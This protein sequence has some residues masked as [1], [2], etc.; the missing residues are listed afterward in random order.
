L[1]EQQTALAAIKVRGLEKLWLVFFKG[2]F[3]NPL[4]IGALA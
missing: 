1:H 2:A 3:Q 4:A